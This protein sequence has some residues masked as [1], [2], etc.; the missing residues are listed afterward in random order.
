[1]SKLHKSSLSKKNTSPPLCPIYSSKNNIHII[2][3]LKLLELPHTPTATYQA[4]SLQS[5]SLGNNFNCFG[6]QVIVPNRMIARYVDKL[7]PI[8]LEIVGGMVTNA[9]QELLIII[10]SVFMGNLY[11]LIYL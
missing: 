8:V 9:K 10:L 1:V 5:T 7:R 11:R 6:K 2:D 4:K 3:F